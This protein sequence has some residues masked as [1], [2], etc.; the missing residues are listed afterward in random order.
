MENGRI[1]KMGFPT[2]FILL[3]SDVYKLF[4]SGDTTQRI[5]DYNLT[6]IY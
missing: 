4:Y 6:I 1:L 2:F 3:E 5:C